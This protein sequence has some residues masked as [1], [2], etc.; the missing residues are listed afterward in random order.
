[1]RLQA[2]P[3]K[4][5]NYATLT[6]IQATTLTPVTRPFYDWEMASVYMKLTSTGHEEFG[7]VPAFFAMQGSAGT[8]STSDLY[9]VYP[10]PTLPSKSV[11]LL[12]GDSWQSR[13]LLGGNVDSQRYAE[14]D[15]AL[16]KSVPC[17]GCNLSRW[18]GSAIIPAPRSRTRS[19]SRR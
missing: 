4:G 16:S 17:A 15:I 1:M 12:P 9:A 8:A 14:R 19:P 18:S 2:L 13:I 5:K 10:L 7:S 3:E 11:R 6:A